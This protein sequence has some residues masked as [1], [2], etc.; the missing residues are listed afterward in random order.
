[1]NELDRT[2]KDPRSH[3]AVPE[4]EMVERVQASALHQWKQ[5]QGA[6]AKAKVA[7]QA[8]AQSHQQPSKWQLRLNRRLVAAFL[9]AVAAAVVLISPSIP[10]L[11]RYDL[12]IKYGLYDL[13]DATAL[14]MLFHPLQ[15]SLLLA[16]SAATLGF[17]LSSRARMALRGLF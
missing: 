14:G 3:R 13:I 15:T 6:T 12:M 11:P 4:R 1:M 2:L 17:A 8:T 16:V 5:E 7:T 10:Q 9:V